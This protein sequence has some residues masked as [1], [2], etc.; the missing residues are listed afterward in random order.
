MCEGTPLPSCTV[1][2]FFLSG[3]QACV[4]ACSVAR[5]SLASRLC[6]CNAYQQRIFLVSLVSR[7]GRR[8][9]EEG[10]QGAQGREQG[11]ERGGAEGESIFQ[12]GEAHVCGCRAPMFE[13]KVMPHPLLRRPLS[14]PPQYW[15]P[16][17]ALQHSSSS[18]CALATHAKL[19]LPLLLHLLPAMDRCKVPDL[20]NAA[21]RGCCCCSC[22]CRTCRPPAADYKQRDAQEDDEEQEAE[23]AAQEGRHKLIR[24]VSVVRFRVR[25]GFVNGFRFR[26]AGRAG[27]QGAR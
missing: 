12:G 20:Q 10:G 7:A 2:G 9:A 6:L 18:L 21:F 13:R 16:V 19:K 1:Q 5:T 3:R 4:P 25:H 15:Q 24:H 22:C 26:A 8:A 27:R 11:Q 14:S 23:E 17:G